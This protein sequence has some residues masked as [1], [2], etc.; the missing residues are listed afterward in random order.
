[1]LSL[2]K[3]QELLGK[4]ILKEESSPELIKSLVPGGK[5]TH[6]GALKVYRNDYVARLTNLLGENY[7]AVWAVLGDELFFMVCSEFIGISDS[8]SFDLGEYGQEFHKFI[9]NHKLGMEFPFLG[10]LAFFELNFLKVF[11]SPLQEPCTLI[12]KEQEPFNLKFK[13]IDGIHLQ[14]SKYPIFKIWE[15]KDISCVERKEVDF[16][17]SAPSNLVL[18]KNNFGIRASFFNEDQI[19]ILSVL[20]NGKNLSES[21]PED[22]TTNEVEEIFKFISSSGILLEV[23]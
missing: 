16:D 6:I 18:Y 3:A 2:S 12:I 11:H 14:K 9:R 23:I 13:F 21:L 8:K 5:L 19:D 4:Y 22:I 15:L 1:M 10:D 7:K 20:L 17:W